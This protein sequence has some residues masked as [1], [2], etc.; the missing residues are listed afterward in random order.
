VEDR[1][2]FLKQ[3][4]HDSAHR[5][6][7]V[8]QAEQGCAERQALICSIPTPLCRSRQAV[9]DLGELQEKRLL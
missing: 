2:F 3:L 9:N 1:I 4:L 6:D 8:Q 5:E 7:V